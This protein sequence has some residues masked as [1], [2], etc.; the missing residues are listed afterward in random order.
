VIQCKTIRSRG[1]KYPHRY[2]HT[3]AEIT[4]HSSVDKKLHRFQLKKCSCCFRIWPRFFRMNPPSGTSRPAPLVMVIPL[5]IRRLGCCAEPATPF[6]RSDLVGALSMNIYGESFVI[7]PASG[8]W[9]S[10]IVIIGVFLF[11]CERVY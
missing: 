7:R 11:E 9:R 3:D 2:T 5:R 6:S 8:A 1:H 10:V 4:E